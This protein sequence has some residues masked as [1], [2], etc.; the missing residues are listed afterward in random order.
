MNEILRK[1][2]V[3]FKKTFTRKHVVV[4]APREKIVTPNSFGGGGW[5]D[6]SGAFGSCKYFR[7]RK[8]MQRGSRYVAIPMGV[9]YEMMLKARRRRRHIRRLIAAA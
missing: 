4:P 5:G 3:W 1:V 6:H 7:A 2:I 9:S 8:G